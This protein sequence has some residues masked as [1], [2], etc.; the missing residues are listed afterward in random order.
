[1]SKD[2]FG[3]EHLETDFELFNQFYVAEIIPVIHYTMGGLKI[4][5]KGMLMDHNDH[6]IPNA[7]AVGEVSGGVHGKDRLAGNSL[8]E[9]MV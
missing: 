1:M 2:R 4:N 5:T 7:Y 6:E 3:R 8:L 9:C